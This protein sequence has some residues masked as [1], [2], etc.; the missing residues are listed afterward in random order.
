ME[1][2]CR[3]VYEALVSLAEHE[4][5]FRLEMIVQCSYFLSACVCNIYRLASLFPHSEA[6]RL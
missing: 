2:A 1:Q 6:W 4:C 3:L 5:V